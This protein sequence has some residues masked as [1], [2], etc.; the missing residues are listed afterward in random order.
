MYWRANNRGKR[1]MKIIARAAACLLAAGLLAA[2]AFATGERAN[3]E[4]KD[5]SGK[6][7]GNIVV[8]ETTG[9][10]LIQLKLSGLTPGAHGFHIHETGACEGDFSSAGG[11][12]NPLGAKHGFTNEEGP[13]AGDL[14]NL[15]VPANGEIEV[16][17]ITTLVSLSGDDGIFDTDGAAFVIFEK[18]DN[19][20]S[21]PEGDAG[22]RIA[23]GVFTK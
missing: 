22:N 6:S 1:T 21:D 14:P 10:A 4:M 8:T 13:M 23:C 20:A 12:L 3:V 7:L 15:I 11:I 9:G 17:L 2:P 18:G 19:Y 16:E 5:A